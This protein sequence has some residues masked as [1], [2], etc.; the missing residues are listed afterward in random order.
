MGGVAG[1]SHK[2]F[3][4]NAPGYF[5]RLRIIHNLSAVT[6]ACLMMR[7]DLFTAIEGFDINYS[8]AFNDVD[9]CMK[10]R[11]KGFLILYTPYAEL[12][13]HEFKTR[14]YDYTA[15]EQAR[16]QR[17]IDLFKQKWGTMIEKGDPFYNSNLALSR[18][19]FSLRVE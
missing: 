6:A 15:E 12:Y 14:G 8:H 2:R 17:E 1:Y 9:L 10:I 19:D 11:Q 16:F 4:R 3:D 13:H 7:K 18:E 5:N